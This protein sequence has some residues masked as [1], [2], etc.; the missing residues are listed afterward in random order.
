[1]CICNQTI[2]GS[3]NGL[4]PGRRQATIST[5]PMPEYWTLRLRNKLQWNLNRN[6]YIF[7]QENAFENV[8]SKMVAILSRPLCVKL[9]ALVWT[10]QLQ[11]P[12]H[13]YNEKTRSMPHLF[14]PR[15]LASP[16]HQQPWHYLCKINWPSSKVN[17]LN[18]LYNLC[19]ENNVFLWFLK[20]VNKING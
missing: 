14:M 18:Y 3:D 4:S 17:M 5:Q 8:V 11:R 15:L 2:I 19:V 16:G 13:V 9:W 20:I 1:M 12:A 10:L 7:G 6:S